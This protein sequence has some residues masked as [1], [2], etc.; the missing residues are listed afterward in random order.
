M[1]WLKGLPFVMAALA[2]GCDKRSLDPGPGT[3]GGGTGSSGFDAG[4]D[5]DDGNVVSGDGCSEICLIEPSTARCGDGVMSGAEECDDGNAN[6][7]PDT[8]AYNHCTTACRLASFC[9]DGVLNVPEECDSGPGNNSVS[10]GNR[11]GC[12]PGCRFPHF[13]GD[14][15][16]DER[17][18][19]QCDIG[20]NKSVVGQCCTV[21]CKILLDC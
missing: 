14:G 11:D 2:I 12:G 20:L 4:F 15:I 16:V 10:Y 5:G 3:G 7:P 1:A 9:G 13:C 19:E 18:G 6:V 8:D 21:D 17:E